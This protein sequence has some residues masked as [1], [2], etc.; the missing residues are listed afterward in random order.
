M[1]FEYELKAIQRF[2]KTTAGLNS[3]RRTATA[4]KLARP[5]VLWESPYS[6]RTQHISR[7]TYQ[8]NKKYY[9]KLYVNDITECIKL[10]ETLICGLEDLCGVLPVLDNNGNR[11]GWIRDAV[12]EFN[13]ASD[14]LEIPFTLSYEVTYA[15][16]KPEAPPAPRVIGTKV[17]VN[18]I[19]QE[20][21]NYGK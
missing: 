7:W 1:N 15:R 13:D 2:I 17:T 11:V 20:G 14:T 16:K 6:G 19:D 10:Q 4:P 21:E 5:V 3:W 18:N 8:Q 9:G 12:L